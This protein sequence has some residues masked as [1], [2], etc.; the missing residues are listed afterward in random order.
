M[1]ATVLWVATDNCVF[2]EKLYIDV[3]MNHGEGKAWLKSQIK[4]WREVWA[5]SAAEENVLTAAGGWLDVFV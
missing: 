3:S 4:L 1:S 2:E 5:F